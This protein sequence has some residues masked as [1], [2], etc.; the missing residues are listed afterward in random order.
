MSA[1][2]HFRY[3]AAKAR[4]QIGL[5]RD[6]AGEDYRFLGKDRRGGFIT[7]G[8]YARKYKAAPIV[9]QACRASKSGSALADAACSG[10][11]NFF[12]AFAVRRHGQSTSPK[13][14]RSNCVLPWHL[15]KSAGVFV[16]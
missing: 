14:G 3:D 12:F 2:R 13:G 9:W 15:G 10:I 7:G 16:K 5:R 4:V 11:Q 6:D 8:F 1:G